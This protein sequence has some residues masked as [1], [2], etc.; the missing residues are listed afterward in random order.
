MVGFAKADSFTRSLH[1]SQL[2][3]TVSRLRAGRSIEVK[4]LVLLVVV[5][6]IALGLVSCSPKERGRWS[7]GDYSYQIG[8]LPKDICIV[9]GTPIVYGVSTESGGGYILVYLRNNGDVVSAQWLTDQFVGQTH[10]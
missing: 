1:H 5:L 10:E 3:L 8:E 2:T 9:N 4:K 6:V 7:G